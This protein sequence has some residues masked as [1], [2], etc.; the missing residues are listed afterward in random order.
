VQNGWI[1]RFAVWAVDSGGPKSTSS[2]PPGEYDWPFVIIR[3]HRS[4]TYVDAA[5]CY[6][7][8]EGGLLVCL[9][10]CLSVSLSQWWALQK[11]LNRS[12]CCLSCGLGWVEGSTTSI[13]FA[14]WRQCAL[15]GGTLALPGAYDWIVRLLQRC[16]LFAVYWYT[17]SALEVVRRCA[18]S[19]YVLLTF[20]YLLTDVKLLLPLVYF[21]LRDAYEI[22]QLINIV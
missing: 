17:F 12:T 20:T 2:T 10:V 16:G 11:R 22:N 4:T 8:I 19:I 3:P 21:A 9:S 13:V 15:M 14:R 1:D 6:R 5:C 7:P 18:I